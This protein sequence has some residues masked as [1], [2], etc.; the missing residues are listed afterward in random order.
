MTSNIHTPKG[1]TLLEAVIVIALVSIVSTI[2]YTSFTALQDRQI[3]DSEVAQVESYIQKARMNS[4]NAKNGDAH[5]VLFGTSTIQIVEVSTSSTTYIY[6]LHNRV[7]LVQST[8]GTS[9]LV[10]ARISGL[11]NATGTL[12]YTYSVGG[13]VK[14]TSTIVVNGLGIIQ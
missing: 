12:T 4:L 7:K 6:T 5:G 14:G 8:L 10:F 13:A 1:F 2:V 9:T 3:L 11:P